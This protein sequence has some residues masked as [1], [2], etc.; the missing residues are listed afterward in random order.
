M[1]WAWG[2]GIGFFIGCVLVFAFIVWR[3]YHDSQDLF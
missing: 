3:D 1:N 2:L